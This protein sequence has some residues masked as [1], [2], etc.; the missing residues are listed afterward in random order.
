M[1]RTLELIWAGVFVVLA[2]TTIA[3]E[4]PSWL[5]TTLV[6]L[7][8]TMVL[9][10]VEMRKPSYHGIGWRRINPGLLAWWESQVAEN[11]G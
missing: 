3:I 6:S 4:F 5:V 9:V 2:G 11:G 7:F 1:V 8:V 10:V